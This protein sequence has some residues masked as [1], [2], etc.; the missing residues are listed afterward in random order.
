MNNNQIDHVMGFVGRCNGDWGPTFDTYIKKFV[1]LAREKGFHCSILEKQNIPNGKS[2]LIT[3]SE[4]G[5][6]TE[7]FQIYYSGLDIAWEYV[8]VRR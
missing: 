7:Y 2:V 5:N 6:Y 8:D 4:N 3:L 1:K